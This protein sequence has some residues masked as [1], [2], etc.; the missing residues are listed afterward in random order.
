V[1]RRSRSKLRIGRRGGLVEQVVIEE[2]PAMSTS[3]DDVPSRKP[4]TT[5][6]TQFLAQGDEMDQAAQAEIE[7]GTAEAA[8]F[9]GARGF[10]RWGA[11]VAVGAGILV[12]G[13]ALLGG[14]GAA[15]PPAALAVEAASRPAPVEAAS[16]PAPVAAPAVAA[17]DPVATAVAATVAAPTVAEAPAPAPHRHAK[18]VRRAHRRR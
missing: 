12:V 11:L 6:E 14:S 7:A 15:L 4:F 18:V 13:G 3:N 9:V 5:M 10:G 17:P 16:R 1:A 8:T 2:V